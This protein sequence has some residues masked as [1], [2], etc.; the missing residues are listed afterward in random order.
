M[1]CPLPLPHQVPSWNNPWALP[2]LGGSLVGKGNYLCVLG[3]GRE[4][5]GECRAEREPGRNKHPAGHPVRSL[6]TQAVLGFHDLSSKAATATSASPS[7][8]VG[9]VLAPSHHRSKDSSAVHSPICVWHRAGSWSTNPNHSSKLRTTNPS[10]S[11]PEQPG[12]PGLALQL[13]LAC[14]VHL[15]HNYLGKLP[16]NSQEQD[17]GAAGTCEGLTRN[18]EWKHCID[19]LYKS[20]YKTRSRTSS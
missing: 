11:I 14:A 2:E 8:W 5:P 20:Y 17:E 7:P 15:F 16:S 13:S 19:R 9:D 1:G 6:P 10:C 4:E 3:S 12:L 18:S